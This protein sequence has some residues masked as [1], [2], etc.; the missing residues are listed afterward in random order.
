MRNRFPRTCQRN[1]K[2]DTE[3][4][5]IISSSD[6]LVNEVHRVARVARVDRGEAMRASAYCSTEAVLTR[7][8]APTSF[9]T[10]LV[11]N[12]QLERHSLGY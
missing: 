7:A 4:S 9:L 5:A 11:G 2:R 6:G 8:A 12:G 3:L 1:D 10:I